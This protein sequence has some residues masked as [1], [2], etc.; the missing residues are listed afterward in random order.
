MSVERFI[1]ELQQRDL[2]SERQLAK[3]R[4]AVV[5]R[6]MSP[7]A[8][9]KFLVQKNHL[10][11][12]QATEVLNAVALGGGDLDAAASPTAPTADFERDP[13]ELMLAPIDDADDDGDSGDDA[14]SSSIFASFLTTRKSKSTK[15]SPPAGED[16]LILLPDVDDA[17]QTEIS[18]GRKSRRGDTEAPKTPQPRPRQETFDDDVAEV[19]LTAVESAPDGLE[20][21]ASAERRAP[22]M[23]T[24]LSRSKGKKDRKKTKPRAKSAKGKWDSPLMLIGG[25]GLA[26]LILVGGLLWWLLIWESGDQKLTLARAAR[27]S[28]AYSEA[29]ERYQD[30]IT[31]SPRHPEHGLAK[32]EL[33]LLRIRQATEAADFEQALTIAETQLKEIEDEEEFDQAHGELAALIPQIAQGLADQTGKADAGSHQA[34]K[35]AELTNKA[36]ELSNNVTYVPKPLRD[37]GKLTVVRETLQLVERRHQTRR[38][39]DE[40]LKTMQEALTG[41]DTNRVYATYAQLLRTHHELADNADLAETLKKTTAAEQAAI[42]FVKEER[43]S[44]TAERPTPWIASLAVANRRIKPEASGAASAPSANTPTT[45][46]IRVDGAVYALDAATGKLLWRRHVGHARLIWPTP[47]G[48]D[49]LISDTIHNELL[50]IESQTGRLKWRQSI[51]EPFAQ[52]LVVGDRGFIAADSGKL[53]VLDLNSGARL[54]YLQFAQP[55]RTAPTVDRTNERLYLT[56]DLSCV[57]SILLKDLSCIGVYYLGHAEGSVTRPP[58]AVMGKL[59][60]LE[61]DGVETSRLRLLSLGEQGA[62]AGQVADRRLTGLASAPPMVA[63]RRLIVFTD[64]GQI[65]VYDIGGEGDEALSLVATRAAAGSTPIVRYVALADRNIWVGDTRLTKYSI[66]PTGNR[67]PVESIENNFTGATFDHP[68]ALFGDTLIHARR[69]KGRAGLIV[70]ATATAQGRT[71]WETD[72]AMPP[73]GA[74]V[75]DEAGKALTA[76]NAEGNLFR[77]DEAAIRSRVQDEPLATQAMPA[78]APALT[79]AID[80]G[81]GRA[82]FCGAGSDHLLLYNPSLGQQGAK[83]IKLE[84]PLAC[85]ATSLG[86]A[87]VAPLTIGQVFLLSAN[88]GSK[89]AMPFQPTLQPQKEWHYTPAAAIDG[90]ANRFVISDGE[91]NIYLIEL[92]DQPQPHLAAKATGN[93]GPNPIESPVVVLGDSA[94]AVAGSSHLLRFKLPSMESVG[95]AHLPAP[96][97]WGPYRVGDTML[98]AT[99][100]NQL[101]AIASDGQIAWQAPLEHGDLAGAPLAQQDSLLIAYRK[102]IVERRSLADGKPLAAKDVEQSLASGPALF[103]QRLVVAANDGTILVVDRP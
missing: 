65:D 76:A 48:S 24:S 47:I 17:A 71:L 86:D 32:V 44:E 80:L 46:C 12:T 61:N 102:G 63:G 98:L 53:Y 23:T 27:D 45:A 74:P 21:I 38:A 51:G 56:G 29:I 81:Q 52:P 83:W 92:A 88:D 13:P 36:L 69:A 28:G 91:E 68:L 18:A 41:G 67:L 42:H 25:G 103:L 82:A 72:L 58:A 73:A 8:L 10:T 34:K 93:V 85:P 66:L 89:V 62:V 95:E 78:K 57:Y 70:A 84:S 60:V 6:R 14:E 99:A 7:N 37:E 4:D 64:R 50:R 11:Q 26:L 77:F 20:Q 54:G 97:V 79:T 39:L 35:A 19:A 22:R 16:E 94:M 30:F 100:N 5:E 2:L 33:V 75:V 3:L 96:V 1:N 59:A 15:P 40:A 31:S 43:P 90:D 49:V 55:F 9:A 101:M 87:I